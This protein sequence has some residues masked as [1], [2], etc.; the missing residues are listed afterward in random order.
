MKTKVHGWVGARRP[1]RWRTCWYGRNTPGPKRSPKHEVR[2]DKGL[3]VAT[4]SIY[5]HALQVNPSNPAV[6]HGT[7]RLPLGGS[8]SRTETPHRPNILKQAGSECITSHAHAG[9][10]F[11]MCHGW[12]ESSWRMAL[13]ALLY[14]CWI[15]FVWKSHLVCRNGVATVVA[16]F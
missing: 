7:L 1:P 9:Q 14:R 15:W 5:A 12:N 10:I 8:R 3:H 2:L 16:P 11:S 6:C 4:R 13:R